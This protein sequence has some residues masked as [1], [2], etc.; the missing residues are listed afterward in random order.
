VNLYT[1]F[2]YKIQTGHAITIDMRYEIRLLSAVQPTLW[3]TPALSALLWGKAGFYQCHSFIL[4]IFYVLSCGIE[5]L[6]LIY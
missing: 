5:R 6:V 2:V 1:Y 3:S 4:L